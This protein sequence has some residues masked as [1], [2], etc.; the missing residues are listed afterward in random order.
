M[1]LLQTEK[2]CIGARTWDAT[3]WY[4]APSRSPESF[5]PWNCT[6]HASPRPCKSPCNINGISRTGRIPSTARDTTSP[7]SPLPTVPCSVLPTTAPARCTPR[8]TQL[9]LK[10]GQFVLFH[11]TLLHRGLAFGAGERRVAVAARVARVRTQIPECGAENPASGG[12]SAAEPFVYYRR[13]GI[14]PRIEQRM[15]YGKSVSLRL[16]QWGT[17]IEGALTNPFRHN[18]GSTL[19]ARTWPH[20]P[21]LFVRSPLRFTL[22]PA[23]RSP[24]RALGFT[25]VVV[26]TSSNLL[27]GC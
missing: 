18:Q 9:P 1:G 6:R 3:H 15:R 22:L 7:S 12:Q 23:R 8:P 11:S 16:C 24:A 27:S 13:S 26:T 17:T 19:I 2:A 20:C 14:L 10:Q 25:T 5:I 21:V 4:Q